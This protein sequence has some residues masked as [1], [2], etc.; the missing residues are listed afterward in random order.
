MT[1]KELAEKIKVDQSAIA[2]W[3]TGKTAP[4]F[5]RL[6]EIA[7]ALSCSVDELVRADEE[8]E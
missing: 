6:S 1:Q 4:R 2:L 7:A 8:N 3:E 5:H